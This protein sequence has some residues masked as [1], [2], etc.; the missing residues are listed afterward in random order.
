MRGIGS[1]R[2]LCSCWRVGLPSCGLWRNTANGLGILHF[3]LG[4][5]VLSGMMEIQFFWDVTPCRCVYMYQRHRSLWTVYFLNFSGFSCAYSVGRGWY[6]CDPMN[7]PPCL[8]LTGQLIRHTGNIAKLSA[9]HGHYT[10]GF[11]RA[12]FPFYFCVNGNNWDRSRCF[13]IGILGSLILCVLYYWVTRVPALLT[14]KVHDFVT[15][16]RWAC[17]RVITVFLITRLC[18]N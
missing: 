15:R 8:Y 2:R 14:H 17:W 4:Y 18:A 3:L 5:E 16:S 6:F 13:L 12:Y 11:I 10:D 1:F 9:Y 7:S